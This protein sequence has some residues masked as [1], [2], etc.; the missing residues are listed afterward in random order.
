MFSR[1]H[2]KHTYSSRSRQLPSS[3]QQ[4]SSSPTSSPNL[5]GKRKRPLLDS[6]VLNAPPPKKINALE[7]LKSVSLTHNKSL[8]TK[9]NPS[10]KITKHTKPT[11]QLHFVVNKTLQTCSRCSFSY[12]KGAVE[13]ETLHRKHC[14]RVTRGLEWGKEEE[15]EA[16]K[17]GVRVIE[18]LLKFKDVDGD[19]FARV[20]SVP[21]STNGKIGAKVRFLENLSVSSLSK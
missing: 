3:L 21:A 6:S 10:K 14:L 7:L 8:K 5:I 13:D 15:R 12:I 16:E 1:P 20:I 2:V 19:V 4:S 18:G 11:T 17:A 9:S